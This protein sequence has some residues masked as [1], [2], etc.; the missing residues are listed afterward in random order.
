MELNMLS[1]CNVKSDH[2]V[3]IAQLEL[4]LSNANV[5]FKKFYTRTRALKDMLDVQSVQEIV[6]GLVFM[7]WSH[8]PKVEVKLFLL[9]LQQP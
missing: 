6:W 3:K 1:C 4:K 9:S 8:N 7:A 2:E 5:S